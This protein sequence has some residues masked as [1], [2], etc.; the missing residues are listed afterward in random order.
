[1]NA[2]AEKQQTLE[3]LANARHMQ[4]ATVRD[5]SPWVCT[6]Y[7]VVDS[8]LNFFWLSTPERRHSQELTHDPRAAIA[9]VIKE[10]LPVIGVQTEGLVELVTDTS[11]VHEIASQYAKKYDGAGEKFYDRFVAGVNKHQLYRFTPK[12]LQLFDEMNFPDSP[13]RKII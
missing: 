10:P 9:V 1:M 12:Y 2:K 5:G 4:L 7:F 3:Y 13:I 6:V 8:E 11:K